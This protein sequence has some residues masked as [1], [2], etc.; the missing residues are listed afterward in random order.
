MYAKIFSVES[1]KFHIAEPEPNLLMI[2]AI[3]TV[4]SSGWSDAQLA[5]RIYIQPPEDGILDLDF[6]AKKPTGMVLWVMLPITAMAEIP[7]EPWIKGFRV[8]SSSNT[9]EVA[10]DDAGCCVESRLI[11]GDGWPW[12]WLQK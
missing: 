5:P 4:N 1:A 7:V 11:P 6:I 3:G 12:P 8:H 9:I 2:N 10:L